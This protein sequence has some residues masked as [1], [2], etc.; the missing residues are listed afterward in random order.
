MGDVVKIGLSLTHLKEVKELIKNNQRIQAIKRVRSKGTVLSGDRDYHDPNG[1]DPNRIGLKEAKYA[2]DNLKARGDR[3]VAVIVPSWE[4]HSLVVSGPAGERIKLDL[5]TLQ[6][7]FLTSL[8]ALGL[9]EVA[10]LMDL[11]AYVQKWQ[12]ND[13]YEST[14][15]VPEA[16]IPSA[17]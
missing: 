6:M 5:E 14:V 7:H 11:M 4:V 8:E 16:Y 13:E 9:E 10:R 12:G 3:S 1:S 2:V 17:K 15:S